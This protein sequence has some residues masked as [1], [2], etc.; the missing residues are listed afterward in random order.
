MS[1]KNANITGTL[2]PDRKQNLPQEIGEKLQ[3]GE[4]VFT[5]HGDISVSRWKDKRDVRVISN[6]HVP[7]MMDPVNKHGKSKGNPKVVYIYTNRM[8]G[9]DRSDQM[10]LFNSAL[11]KI[12]KGYKKVGKSA[13]QH[14]LHVQQS[15]QQTT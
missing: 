3:E 13:Q 12:V 2:R 10:L 15:P 11:R 7:T 4:M 9:I 1:K 6:A 14:L 8:L 5:S